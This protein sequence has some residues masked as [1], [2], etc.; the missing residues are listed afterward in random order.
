LEAM[1]DSDQPG[2]RDVVD[3]LIAALADDS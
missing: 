1:P 3:A 2:C